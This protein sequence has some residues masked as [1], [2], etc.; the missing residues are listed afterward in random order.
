[1]AMATARHAVGPGTFPEVLVGATPEIAAAMWE[2]VGGGVN[3]I[4]AGKKL[5]GAA[6]SIAQNWVIA[7]WM[8]LGPA[9][10]ADI[11]ARVARNAFMGVPCTAGTTIGIPALAAWK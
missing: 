10:G 9:P 7:F 1:M 5:D 4:A 2:R 8:A 3:I 6:A 11:P